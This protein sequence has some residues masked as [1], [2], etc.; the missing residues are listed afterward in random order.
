MIH[1]PVMSREV[2][3]TLNPQAGD[4]LL[5]ATVGHGG[6][7]QAYLSAGGS[8]VVGIDADAAALAVAQQTL[9]SNENRARLIVGTF[10]ALQELVGKEQFTHVLFDLGIGSHQLADPKRGFSFQATGPLTMRYASTGSAQVAL[11]PS[12]I[13]GIAWLERRLGFPPD[14]REL[15]TGLPEA[16][17]ADLIWQYGEERYSRRIA[18]AIKQQ[19][20]SIQTAVELA[21]AI[22]SATPASYERGRMHPATRTFQAFRLA[23]NR[24]LESLRLALPQAVNVLKDGGKLAVISFHSLE[25]RIVKQYFKQ[26]ARLK[27][28]TKKPIQAEQDEIQQNSRSRSA[29]LR[30]AQKIDIKKQTHD[31][32]HLTTRHPSPPR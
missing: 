13:Q 19:A 15:I 14:V 31:S 10:A 4:S 32:K 25:D 20:G 5:D 24:E 1:I 21:Q 7:T 3:V 18:R 26:D 22:A 11:P 28:L 2:M 9:T 23:V 12:D 29:K 8:R 17:L 16:E 27:I 6:H 30:V